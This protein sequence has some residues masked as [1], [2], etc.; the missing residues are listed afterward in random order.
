MQ[1]LDE[2]HLFVDKEIEEVLEK[3]LDDL[4]EA[5]NPENTEK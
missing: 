3:K 1:E 5:M 4:M 2:T